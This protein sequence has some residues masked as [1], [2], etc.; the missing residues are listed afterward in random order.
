MRRRRRLAAVVAVSAGLVVGA[1]SGDGAKPASGATTTAA[2]VTTTTVSGRPSVPTVATTAIPGAPTPVAP[3]GGTSAPVPTTTIPL[4][5]PPTGGAPAATTSGGPAPA[6]PDTTAPTPAP[7]AAPTSAPTGASGDAAA[8]CRAVDSILPLY[9]ATLL[10]VDSGDGSDGDT[11]FEVAVAPALAPPVHAAAAN[12]PAVVAAP[13]QRWAARADA[14]IA[15]LKGAGATD[16]QVA[17]LGTAFT[18]QVDQAMSGGGNQTPPDPVEAAAN[19]GID[20]SRLTAATSAFTTANGDFD[21]FAG[22]LGQDL[23]LT[24]SQVDQLSGQYPC[25][26]DLASFSG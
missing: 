21:T 2:A 26:A 16:A 5:P 18:R 19:A 17:A 13:F 24:P 3:A 9:L 4:T 7:T 8:F 12:A 1:C 22:A 23:N 15:T 14:A 10:L 6:A 11:R 20:A 25:A